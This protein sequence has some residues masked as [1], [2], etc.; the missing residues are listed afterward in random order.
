MVRWAAISGAQCAGQLSDQMERA[1]LPGPIQGMR[2]KPAAERLDRD[3]RGEDD[4]ETG[5]RSHG[6]A[7]RNGA[8]WWLKRVSERAITMPLRMKKTSTAASPWEKGCVSHSGSAANGA[9]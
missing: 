4:E 2:S 9:M 8:G 6:R 7:S 5:S 1:A 3:G